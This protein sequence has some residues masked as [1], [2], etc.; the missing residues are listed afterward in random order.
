MAIVDI[1]FRLLV[2]GN[3]PSTSY[4]FSLSVEGLANTTVA[5]T[6]YAPS[7]VIRDHVLI[8]SHSIS[9]YVLMGNSKHNH[10][11]PNNTVWLF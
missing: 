11:H 9:L 4:C 10:L 1:H 2:D 3:L 8:L 6:S 7:A 5:C